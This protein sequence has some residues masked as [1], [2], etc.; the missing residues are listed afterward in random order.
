MLESVQSN[1][2]TEEPRP[3]MP[4]WV[5]EQGLINVLYADGPVWP[6]P[7]ERYPVLKLDGLPGGMLGY[8]YARNPCGFAAVH[9][10]GGWPARP[11]DLVTLA[12][13]PAILGG[14]P[15]PMDAVLSSEAGVDTRAHTP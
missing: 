4:I 15:V 11:T 14:R 10:A 2:G 8:D 3:T 7:T 6:L 1:F 13:A 5:W 12:L 9:F